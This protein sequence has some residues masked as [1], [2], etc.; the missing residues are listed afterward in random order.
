MVAET[1]TAKLETGTLEQ[2]SDES[3]KTY[4]SLCDGHHK[5]E[6]CLY[7][8]VLCMILLVIIGSSVGGYCLFV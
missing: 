6:L 8:I 1:S 4:F 3:K 5:E 7:V 2:V